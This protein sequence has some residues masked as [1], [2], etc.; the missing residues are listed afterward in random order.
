M[1]AHRNPLLG[2]RLFTEKAPESERIRQS[3][4]I[5][6]IMFHRRSAL[7]ATLLGFLLASCT[8]TGSTTLNGEEQDPTTT[9]IEEFDPEDMDTTQAIDYLSLA[10]AAFNEWVRHLAYGETEEA[11]QMLTPESQQAF[12]G[13]DAFADSSTAMAEGWGA[14]TDASDVTYVVYTANPDSLMLT[15]IGVIR[16]E[17][18]QENRQVDIPFVLEGQRVLLSPFED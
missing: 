10:T 15:V 3:Q 18:V 17:G 4:T 14:W 7:V 6:Q 1:Y 13:W 12:G 5:G 2:K 11:W 16:P 9:T 8:T